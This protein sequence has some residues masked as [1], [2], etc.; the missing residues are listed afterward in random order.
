MDIPIKITPCPIVDSTI[1]L[2]FETEIDHSAVF[3]MVYSAFRDKT[4]K[5]EHLPVTQIPEAIR[6]KD[7]NLLHQPHHKLS[8]DNF[9]IQV[10]P[11]AISLGNV[12]EY[13]GWR[14][15]L[16]EATSVFQKFGE[17][18]IAKKILR[19]GLRYIN[20]FESDI[21][22]KIDLS[23]MQREKA[24]KT[25]NM[26][27]RVEIK[28]NDF[29]NTLQVANNATVTS[30]G[31]TRV[32]SIIDIDT[33]TTSALDNLFVNVSTRL[34]DVHEE[35]KKLFFS[36]LKPDFLDTLNPEYKSEVI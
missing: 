7:P 5:T 36:L 3:G 21:F 24:L 14:D 33:F 12:G 28:R 17:I 22:D 2:R 1:E 4:K 23:I 26:F 15:F 6:F 34:I 25:D 11:S 8:Y 30:R 10:G 19:L 16:K 32:G 31:K 27:I 29:V 35:E 18:G 9:A 13:I 20:Y